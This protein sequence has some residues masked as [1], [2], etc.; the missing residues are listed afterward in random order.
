LRREVVEY[1]LIDDPGGVATIGE[2]PGDLGDDTIRVPVFR[3]KAVV[4]KEIVVTSEVVI[5][6]TLTAERQTLEETLRR[7]TV[8]VEDNTAPWEPARRH[9]ERDDILGSDRG[10]G[11]YPGAGRNLGDEK[12]DGEL[13]QRM[14]SRR[15]G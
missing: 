4:H 2:A 6:R 11:A 5:D 1:R 14:D 13:P 15:R 3:E 9:P 7:A 10:A 12:E 8:T